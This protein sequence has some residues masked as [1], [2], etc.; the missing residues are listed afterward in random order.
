MLIY[1]EVYM[2]DKKT[3]NETY[4]LFYMNRLIGI[5]WVQAIKDAE[6]KTEEARKREIQGLCPAIKDLERWGEPVPEKKTAGLALAPRR[7]E[8]AE[9]TGTMEHGSPR[10]ARFM[11][12]KL[13]LCAGG[14]FVQPSKV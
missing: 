10:N 14:L 12:R 3:Q 2:N 7:V 1:V 9:K 4:I 8:R 11:C 5:N 13:T 6:F